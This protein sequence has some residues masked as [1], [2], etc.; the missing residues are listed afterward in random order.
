VVPIM[1]RKTLGVQRNGDSGYVS[2]IDTFRAIESRVRPDF[3]KT[4]VFGLAALVS[5]VAGHEVGGVHAESIRVRL[6]SYGCALAAAIFGV[7]ASR[8]AAREVQRVAVARAGA[9]AGTPLRLAILLV[10]YVIVG[11]SV[12]DLVGFELK[13]LLVGGAITG[14]VIGLA[15]QPV[16]S[17]LFA[18]LVLLFARPYVPGQRIRVMSGALNG[19]HTGVV[20]SAGLLYTML[21]TAD[22][23]LNIPNS[24]LLAA[25]VGPAPKDTDL[26]DEKFDA[27]PA[28]SQTSPADANGAVLAMV[29]AGSESGEQRKQQDQ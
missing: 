2:A 4:I 1:V 8:T 5:L 10:G 15:A 18:G 28:P 26:D 7:A 19:P 21:E 23:P 25:A 6:I 16:L 27:A 12:C 9:A 29:V 11:I 17:N 22:G 24:G 13:Q 14:I 3:R 20:V